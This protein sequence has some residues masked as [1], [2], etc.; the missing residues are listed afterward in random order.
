M[1]NTITRF[2]IPVPIFNLWCFCLSNCAWRKTISPLASYLRTETRIFL[3]TKNISN[4]N[5]F[6]WRSVEA[7]TNQRKS[8]LNGRRMP[9]SESW[10]PHKDILQEEYRERTGGKN[11]EGSSNNGGNLERDPGNSWKPHCIPWWRANCSKWGNRKLTYLNHFCIVIDQLLKPW[12]IV[13]C[14][15]NDWSAYYISHYSAESFIL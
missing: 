10:K 11:R 5:G 1:W 12:F 6:K 2:G 14:V 8:T 15:L 13:L 9:L 7:C 4:D 3:V